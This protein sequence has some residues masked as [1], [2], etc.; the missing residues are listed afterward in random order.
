MLIILRQSQKLK[1]TPKLAILYSFF[2][3][4]LKFTLKLAIKAQR[5]SYSSTLSLTSAV[6]EIWCWRQPGRFTA[7]NDLVP[8]VQ[9]PGLTPGP[10]CKGT[11]NLAPNGIRLP[12]RP[13]YSVVSIPTTVSQ[14]KL[15]PCKL[16]KEIIRRAVL[17]KE[18]QDITG[19]ITI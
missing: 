12:D 15:Q 19:Y 7:G 5:K 16:M 17:K 1:F 6:D 8:S 11:E 4:C 3:L 9:Q 2:N 14:P 18:Q 13:A 10:V